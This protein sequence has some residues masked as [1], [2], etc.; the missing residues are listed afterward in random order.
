[1]TGDCSSPE[2]SGVDMNC[3]PNYSSVQDSADILVNLQNG[4]NLRILSITQK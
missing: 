1:M 4:V 2:L 3:T